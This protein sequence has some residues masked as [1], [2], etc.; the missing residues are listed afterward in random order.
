MSSLAN[1]QQNLSFPGLLQVPGGITST[2]Q[3]VQDGD[4]NV[5]GL[6]LSSA[7]ASV[8]TSSTF[9]AS[10]NGT[11]ITGALPRLISDGFGDFISVKDFGATGDGVTDDTAAISLAITSNRTVHFPAGT[12][13][14]S[15]RIYKSALSN[16]R[17][18]GDGTGAT[19]IICDPSA[20]FTN[21]PLAFQSCT[22][23]WI[24]GITFDQ[25]DNASLSAVRSVIIAS[26]TNYFTFINNAIKRWTYGGVAIESSLYFNISNNNFT[27]TTTINSFN[28]SII[29]SS[30]LS[31]SR[32]GMINNNFS[33][34]AGFIVRG[35][36]ITIENNI[37]TGS[38]YGGGLGLGADLTSTTQGKYIVRN[39]NF[40]NSAGIDTDGTYCCGMEVSGNENIISGNICEQNNGVGIAM[41]G[42]K[43]IVSNNS[44]NDNGACGVT[45]YETGISQYRLP[46]TYGSFNSF[47]GNTC[48]DLGSGTQKYGYYEQTPGVV[49]NLL[50]GNN[51]SN[52]V[53]GDIYV[54]STSGYY[55]TQGWTSYTPVM[56]SSVGAIT[57]IGTCTGSFKLIG[58][59]VFFEFNCPITTNGTGAG[60][61][62]VTLPKTMGSN[63]G[64]FAG[65]ESG[66]TGNML[67]GYGG[68]GTACR[69]T[70]YDS[71]YPGADGAVIS[72]SGTY[73]TT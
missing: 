27:K 66:V 38:T 33:Q 36:S 24:E 68:G 63:S 51:F 29:V 3:Q 57:T 62:S 2:L 20:N 43:N 5:T 67:L 14:I 52:N 64:R 31:N 28:C 15:S 8:T 12:Y 30:A 18:I 35:V 54:Q 17:L 32:Y 59:T 73:Q 70:L 21:S 42:Y 44:C 26:Q 10:K 34:Y 16:V 4:G 9:Q 41:F 56:T 45:G 1:Q 13:L 72:V 40:S 49:G 22:N 69:V 47:I 7:G 11:T 46:A 39:N 6:S 25:Q 23:V 19:T 58:R 37:V 50:S 60:F 65:R 71:T 53:T 55:E 48:C 61:I